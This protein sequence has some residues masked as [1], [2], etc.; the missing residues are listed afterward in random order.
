M[1]LFGT[2][3]VGYT[4]LFTDSL[5]TKVTADN[6]TNLNTTGFKGAR[7]EFADSLVRY[8]EV[9]GRERGYGTHIKAI[10]TLFT[11]GGI[12]TTDL[13][14][15]LAIN[16]KGYFIVSDTKGNYFYTR[17]GQFF[18]N[19]VDKDYFG[20]QNSLRM[21]LL[22]A[23]PKVEKGDLQGL[24]PTLI[25]KVMPAKATSILA[26]HLILDSRKP[27]N[28]QTLIEKYDAQL[29]PQTPLTEGKYDWVFDLYM[30]DSLGE[31]IPL[32]LY[33][34]KGDNPNT[35]EILLGLTDSSTDGRG[36]GKMQGAFLYGNLT[37]GGSGEIVQADFWNVNLDGTL[38]PIDL[39]AFGKPKTTLNIKGNSQELLLDLGFSVKPN[40]SIEREATSIKMLATPFSQLG[41]VQD[42]YPTGVFERIEVINEE[43]LI[44]AWYTN[45]KEIEVARL[46]LADFSGYEDSLIKI[47]NGLFTAKSGTEVYFFIPGS[48]E[49]GR[50]LS[51]ALETSNVDLA[52]E[53]ISLIMLQRSFQSNSR[54]IT[55]ADQML[56]DF[57]RQR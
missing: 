17:D 28:S 12:Q 36:A 1:G 48:G 32:R 21:S 18:I 14:T 16:G 22:G 56:E 23:D 50:I 8:S 15:D 9:F 10:R 52:N 44:R 26:P 46:F 55:T 2:M 34:D 47:G 40:G 19:E 11:Q 45:Q 37:F 4:G 49:R 39:T 33:V 38:S 42:G 35:Y 5:A 7:S 43:G 30:Y 31:L 25:P 13:P 6:I 51:G 3:Y 53:M 41:F 20:L 24:K 57:L 29:S 54:V 27:I